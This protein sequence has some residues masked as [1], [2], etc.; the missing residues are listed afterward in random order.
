M[1][2]PARYR[3]INFYGGRILQARE[4][5][6]LQR[7]QEGLNSGGT[8]RIA[9]DLDAL[10][11]E[12]A[13]FNITA[14]VVSNVV[15]LSATNNTYPMKVFVRG[16]WEYLQ[17]ADISN[18][19]TLATGAANIYINWVI[20]QVTSSEDPTLVDTNTGEPTADMGELDIVVSTADTSGVALSGTQFE[21]N[22]VPVILFQFDGNRNLI[23]LDN[24]KVSALAAISRSGLV[25]LT[26]NTANGVAV[27][28]DDPRIGAPADPL[29]NSVINASVRTPI[30]VGGNNSDGT[31]I[32]NLINDEGGIDSVKLV[33]SPGNQLVSDVIQWIKGQIANIQGI[34]TSHIGVKLG[35]PT[36][37]PMPTATDVG[38]TPI[39]H[40]GQPL[41]LPTSHPATVNTNSG[42]YQ[43]NRNASV[44][45]IANDPAY[46]VFSNGSCVGGIY[47]NGDLFSSTGSAISANPVGTTTTGTLNVFSTVAHVLAEHVN[48]VSHANPHGLSLA[49]LGFTN[50][51][52]NANGFY[53]KHPDGTIESWGSVQ[54]PATGNQFAQVNITFPTPYTTTPFVQLSIVGL[55]SPSAH[56]NDIASA[57]ISSLNTTGG[58]VA[59]Q[60]SVPEGGGGATFDNVIT[61]QYYAIGY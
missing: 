38:A 60:T 57:Q 15:T 26:T 55:P 2:N 19:M 17:S 32:Y 61:L 12:G 29:P 21:K 56:A 23:P 9:E 46:G 33:H 42:G 52:S 31:P 8:T 36:T 5:D 25:S 45:P 30:P 41:G 11:R 49:D 24:V 54:V 53:F 16:R 18:S 48:Q 37:H 13:T 50:R 7:I 27:A 34:L 6:Q 58:V 10:Y 40:V 44:V 39:S 3:Y 1:A 20:R 22:T 28:T 43:L 47:H 14:T 59:L 51:V 4:V 35:F